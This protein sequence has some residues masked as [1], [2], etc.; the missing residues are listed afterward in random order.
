MFNTWRM[1]LFCQQLD[2]VVFAHVSQ[3]AYV[4]KC[5]E[6]DLRDW[7]L[8]SC[9][10]LN[11]LLT[12]IKERAFPDWDEI[13]STLGLN[14]HIQEE[15][16]DTEKDAKEKEGKETEKESEVIKDEGKEKDE[17]EEPKKEADEAKS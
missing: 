14:T 5:V 16:K 17:K 7:F 8:E 6:Y 3:I 1:F 15:K 4:D 11:A 12:R 9:P 2:I 13:T 10:K